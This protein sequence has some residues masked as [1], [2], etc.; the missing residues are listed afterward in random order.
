MSRVVIS[1]LE[2]RGKI[3]CTPSW[4]IS[5]MEK[6]K[7]IPGRK[8]FQDKV[9]HFE[10]S[11]ENVSFVKSAF[12][13]AEFIKP[14]EENGQRLATG[15]R[16]SFSTAMPMTSLQEQAFEHFEGKN[17]FA[18]FEKPGSG[19]TKMV[20]DRAVKLWC[21]GVIDGLF[22]ISYATVHEQWVY[23]EIPKHISEDIPVK[24]VF[25]KSGKKQDESILKPD[26]DTFRIL[27]MNYE[28]YSNSKIG[29]SFAKSFAES[30]AI[31]IVLDESQRIKDP[32]S[33]IGEALAYDRNDYPVRA[34]A[35]G[36]PIPLGIQ[37]YYNQ[38]YFLDPG[39]V[40]AWTFT[41]FKSM[42]CR[43]GGFNNTKIVGYQNTEN[44]H[45]LM[46]PYVHVG[47][48]DIDAKQIFQASRFSLG[49]K[50]R[51]AYDQMQRE[52]MVEMEMEEGQGI[53][54]VARSRN[55]LAKLSKLHEIACERMKTLDDNV[56]TFE[57][58]RMDLLGSLLDIYSSHKTI[59]WSRFIADHVQQR[60]MLGEKAAVFNGQ[61]P[62]RERAE[63]IKE[64]K[65]PTSKLQY[66]LA[67]EGAAGTGLNLQGGCKLNIYYSSSNNAGNHWQSQMRTYRIGTTED[68]NYIYM[69]ARN[70]V[71]IGTINSNRRKREVADMSFEEFRNLINEK[72]LIGMD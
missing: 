48:P 31:M 72:E 3:S 56:I 36:E 19:K 68:V 52:L 21:D 16:R 20:L 55:V 58:N 46:A 67:S 22:V 49:P 51:A 12:P 23:D 18:F 27:T 11:K 17:L 45:R 62:K 2:P 70:T 63:I 25:W 50:A 38:F 69:A 64:F 40:G 24:A 65:D 54:I 37:D 7:A 32:E 33:K 14:S 43:F 1:L 8:K 26:K 47:A 57:N 71:D 42:Y 30:G 66:L 34:L 61:T 39:I 5:V 29:S 60:Q 4:S 15:P 9:M 53:Q 6:A 28:A 59:V 44:L 13:M 10:L 35:S 41:G